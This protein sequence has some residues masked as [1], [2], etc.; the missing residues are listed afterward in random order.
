[1]AQGK[2]RCH[3]PCRKKQKPAQT[4]RPKTIVSGRIRMFSANDSWLSSFIPG[5]SSDLTITAGAP[6]S[7]AMSPVTCWRAAPVLQRRVRAGLAPAS[8]FIRARKT[9]PDTAA[10]LFTYGYD[11]TAASACQ[12]RSSPSSSPFFIKKK[13]NAEGADTPRLDYICFVL[14]CFYFILLAWGA[15]GACARIH[16]RPP[17]QRILAAARLRSQAS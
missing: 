2:R 3:T 7:R 9:A 13:E 10:A 11:S 8:L 17:C 5:R 6:S 1:M 12:S 16:R 4:R 15:S 14:I